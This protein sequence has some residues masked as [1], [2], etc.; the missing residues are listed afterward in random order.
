MSPK[1][2]LDE[3][4][5]I[6]LDDNP[7]L[8]VSYSYFMNQRVTP[9]TSQFS[10]ENQEARDILGRDEDWFADEFVDRDAVHVLGQYEG[11]LDLGESEPTEFDDDFDPRG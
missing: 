3:E 7:M 8:S 10:R 5:A 6:E 1:L 2:T 9:N 4:D 11:A